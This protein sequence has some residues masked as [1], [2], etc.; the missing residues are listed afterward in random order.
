MPSVLSDR[1]NTQADQAAHKRRSSAGSIRSASA[2]CSGDDGVL[3]LAPMST[4]P[5]MP[6]PGLIIATADLQH[7][8]GYTVKIRPGL[9]IDRAMVLSEHAL[10]QETAADEDVIFERY[11]RRL[12]WQSVKRRWFA[13]LTDFNVE[14]LF[15]DHSPEFFVRYVRGATDALKSELAT[16]GDPADP[17]SVASLLKKGAI[18]ILLKG[19]NNVCMIKYRALRCLPPAAAGVLSSLAPTSLSDVDFLL[20]IDYMVAPWLSEPAHFHQVHEACRH[21]VERALTKLSVQIETRAAAG[22]KHASNFTQLLSS[23]HNDPE[24]LSADLSARL[25]AATSGLT[26]DFESSL[27]GYG[28]GRNLPG[29]RTTFSGAREMLAELRLGSDAQ[30][31][32]CARRS[33][34][35]DKD[36]SGGGIL[37]VHAE[38]KHLFVSNNAGVEHR[39]A[40]CVLAHETCSFALVRTLLGYR[41]TSARMGAAL[42]CCD[43]DAEDD[44]TFDPATAACELLAGADSSFSSSTTSGMTSRSR[45]KS[46]RSSRLLKGEGVDVSLP[47]R[48]DVNLQLWCEEEASAPGSFIQSA[49]LCCGQE[50]VELLVPH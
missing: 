28:T 41:V 50:S 47:T 49:I 8:P 32:P 16:V 12:V 20:M 24:T 37:Q 22:D 34:R 45:D 9:V 18:K 27:A 42:R 21:A 3:V 4:I 39:D 30:V 1:S 40:R 43:E 5:P 26:E 15:T 46:I 29:W 11:R 13:A 33:L 31:L 7:T 36:E 14:R 2:S 19:G 38:P 44:A 23:L 48:R 10:R 6:D 25:N 35:I 17:H